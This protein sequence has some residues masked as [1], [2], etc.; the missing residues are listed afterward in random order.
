[1]LSQGLINPVTKLELGISG[2]SKLLQAYHLVIIGVTDPTLSGNSCTLTRAIM[3]L[4]QRVTICRGSPDFTLQ[5]WLLQ[6]GERDTPLA[7][8]L[9]HRSWVCISRGSAVCF[10]CWCAGWLGPKPTPRPHHSLWSRAVPIWLRVTNGTRD[11]NLIHISYLL[12]LS[13]NAIPSITPF[14]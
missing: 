11:N 9:I 7:A 4:Q 8:S 12:C 5:S 13:S 1:M 10:L 2:G 3:C 14:C 6:I